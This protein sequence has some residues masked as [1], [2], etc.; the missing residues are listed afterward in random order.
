MW[1]KKK[2]KLLISF[3]L[4]T[5]ISY[6]FSII[7]SKAESQEIYLTLDA[8]INGGGYILDYFN[9]IKN[10]LKTVGIGLNVYNLDWP[11]FIS[12]LL[13]YHSYDLTY[14]SLTGISKDPDF[15]SIYGKDSPMKIFG[16]NSSMDWDN[17]L[18]NGKNQWYLE[19]G[20]K[21]VPPNSEARINHY[22]D[23]EMYLMDKIC[24]I[25]P[26]FSLKNYMAYWAN[27]NGYNY[28]NGLLN[29]WGKMSWNE[30]H[31][32]QNDSTAI[33]TVG[34]ACYS[35]NPF[36]AFDCGGDDSFYQQAVLDSLIVYDNDYTV[37]PHLA[38]EIQHI[39]DTHI[40][41]SIREGI[42]WADDPD[43][44]FTNVSFTASDAYFTLF[45][46]KH[47]SDYYYQWIKDMEIIDDYTL[48]VFIDGD[49]E[50]PE[51]DV[52]ALYM[53]E[54]DIPMLPEHYLNQTQLADNTTPDTTH[55]SWVK[56]TKEGF[57]TGLFSLNYSDESFTRLTL[58]PNS[59][60]LNSTITSDPALAWQARFG[61]FS[62]GLT[63]LNVYSAIEYL[64]SF[65]YFE[66]GLLDL[67]DCTSNREKWITYNSNPLF[68][69]QEKLRDGYL[70][71]VGYNLREDREIIGSLNPAPNDPSI[72]IGLAIRKAINY[73][74]NR[75]EINTVV[76]SG[77]YVINHYPIYQTMKIWCNPNILRYEHDVLI[78]KE[79]LYKAGYGDSSFVYPG[80]NTSITII[81]LFALLIITAKYSFRKKIKY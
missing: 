7:P 17:S 53:T 9:L 32:G 11:S 67:I 46:A 66:D 23:W 58:N 72:T 40:R 30:L 19:E 48:D 62:G 25:L 60:W 73:A 68:T 36:I 43:G 27:L 65:N 75:E 21:I 44:N 5:I 56:F 28:T 16:Y 77:E 80:F 81:A 26:L 24:P 29:S 20:L 42:K 50:T 55:E 63:I 41:I 22:W 37:W 3:M 35:L 78:A 57:G 31:A 47:L 14:I 74:I 79:Y 51:I 4:I 39:D 18:G 6:S 38:K 12:E 59:W 10:Q 1:G 34:G 13:V 33:N 61:D 2:A 76:H 15:I 49:P 52:T 54:L 69:N 71:F 64:D 45:M 8:K 70:S